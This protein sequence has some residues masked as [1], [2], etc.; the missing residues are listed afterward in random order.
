MASKGILVVECGDRRQQTLARDIRELE[1]YSEI[2]TKDLA[3][4]QVEDLSSRFA[5]I[6]LAEVSDD[7]R[8]RLGEEFTA[9]GLPQLILRDEASVKETKAL[10]QNFVKNQTR[11]DAN[12]TLD[13]YVERQIQAIRQ[14][15]GD[16]RAICGLSGG[17]DSSVAATLV[18]KAIGQQ[19]TLVFVDHGLMRKNEGDQV[20]AVFRDQLGANFIRVNAQDRFLD[21]LAGVT[22]PEAK[23]K[24]IGEEFI[25]VFEDEAAEIGE[26]D[27][28]VQGTIY[29]DVLES[30]RGDKLVKS[31]HNVGGLPED[32][33][34]Q[35]IIEPLRELF[36][37]E[38]R[39]LGAHLGLPEELVWRQPFP[40]PGLAV[41]CLGE[42]TREKLDILRD[43]DAIFREEIA[44]AGLAHELSQ[45]FAVLTNLRSV[46]V[47]NGE[48]TYDYVLALR[49]IKTR[50][51]MTAEWARLPYDLLDKVSRRITDEVEGVSRVV[52]E[53][54]GKPPATIEWE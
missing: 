44:A 23:R 27:F 19:L 26:A 39:L 21:K 42:C 28:L 35:G 18:Y 43:A 38:V 10:V 48:R 22:D 1:V 34:F 11:A 14:Q 2:M 8:D 5:G 45:Y 6:I 30:Q 25:R 37:D 54:T 3:L 49:A 41:R 47:R 13:A 40:G 20:E 17:V 50:D 12:W 32:I 9:S 4:S 33:E 31:H 24:I 36:K 52:Y 15:V 29:P 53:I 16:R 51:F 46:G 7:D